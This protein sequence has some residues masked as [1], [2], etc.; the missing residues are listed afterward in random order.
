[1]KIKNIYLLFIKHQ[2]FIQIKV[3]IEIWSNLKNTKIY[4]RKKMLIYYQNINIMI[5][6]LIFENKFNYSLN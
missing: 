3:A 5:L 4:L 2:F 6:Q 1:M